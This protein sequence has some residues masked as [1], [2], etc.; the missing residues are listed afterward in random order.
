MVLLQSSYDGS[1]VRK[2]AACV[3]VN[4]GR[5]G[6][7]NEEQVMHAMSIDDA[8]H[9]ERVLAQGRGGVTELVTLDGSGPF[10]RKKMPLSH[11]RRNVWAALSSCSCPRLPQVVAT[12]ELP[13]AFVAVYGYVPGD[14]LAVC[15]EAA[16]RFSL[17]RAL[18]TTREV[19][20]AVEDLHRHGVIHKD[21]AP[22]NV[23][24]AADG[25]HVIDFGIAR[26]L[27]GAE[28]RDERALGTW[29]FAA[30]EQY[31]FAQAD[32]RSDVYALGRLLGYMLT[33][34]L[35]GDDDGAYEKLVADDNVVA[36][37][38][39]AVVEKASAFEPS[40]RYQSVDELARALEALGDKLA[41]ADGGVF[42]AVGAVASHAFASA[43]KTVAA[44]RGDKEPPANTRTEGPSAS[45]VV[46][47]VAAALIALAVVAAVGFAL[48]HAGVF[49]GSG[50][51]ES[52]G[53][54]GQ[55]SASAQNAGVS[56]D[57][58][59]T[60]AATA[61]GGN[62]ASGVSDDVVREAADA[63]EISESAWS[64]DADGFVYFC[65]ALTNTSD[66]LVVDLPSVQ[67]T[68]RDATGSVVFSTT[69]AMLL[70]QPG[71]TTYTASLAEGSTA[72]ERVDFTV[73]DPD[74]WNVREAG[75]A[76]SS[77]QV[78]DVAERSNGMGGS[79]FTG[80]VTCT[81]VD[82]DAVSVGGVAVTVVLRDEAGAM[83]YGTMSFA[84]M[85]SVGETVPFEVTGMGDVPPHASV[86]AYAQVW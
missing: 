53:Q 71:E 60:D 38:V 35:S 20:E 75:D 39:R 46:Q 18:R 51:A 43:E 14:T 76:R 66:H 45:R 8:Y 49:A 15:V 80:E 47:R 85:P 10:V 40:A 9:V 68:G 5:E 4:V 83:V 41:K 6:A 19:C 73:V 50:T 36:P 65:F 21:L 59:L 42:P 12:Y 26:V 54:E 17:D 74:G 30:P 34:V 57:G 25:A 84:D 62:A 7:L 77:L 56:H 3:A 29:G 72:V 1:A 33:G 61:S 58:A 79:T 2:R 31:G 78:L 55:V 69:Q 24:I 48:W 28:D 37:A 32:E 13:D 16:G 64:V 27:D 44:E 23:V 22:G 70:V 86:E 81:S 52:T 11:V 67:I 63:L 82:P